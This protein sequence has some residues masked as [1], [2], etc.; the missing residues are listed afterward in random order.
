MRKYKEENDENAPSKTLPFWNC[1]M[2][3]NG[4]VPKQCR[5]FSQGPGVGYSLHLCKCRDVI[6]M[7]LGVYA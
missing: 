1:H 6:Q 3:E 4:N 5:H 2:W 7:L